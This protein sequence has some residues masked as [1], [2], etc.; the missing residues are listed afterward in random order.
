M[1]KHFPKHTP[2]L[3]RYQGTYELFLEPN[4]MVS[5]ISNACGRYTLSE[6]IEI[7]DQ[8]TSME[9]CE[10][11]EM[12]LETLILTRPYNFAMS[13]Q[14]KWMKSSVSKVKRFLPTLTLESRNLR[15]SARSAPPNQ[16]PHHL[17]PPSHSLLFQQVFVNTTIHLLQW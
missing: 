15:A 13:F 6:F 11:Y 7:R 17:T 16:P 8:L 2:T 12:K 1:K 4:G 3:W 5:G 14:P 9:W 10:D